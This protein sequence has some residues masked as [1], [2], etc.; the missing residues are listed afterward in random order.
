MTPSPTI[1]PLIGQNVGG[2]V[3]EGLI[4]E[5]GMGLVYRARHPILERRFAVKVLRPD[6][7]ADPAIAQN[8]IREAQTLSAI[9]HPNIIDI[10]GF[11][12]LD[13]GRQFMVTE[14]L[15]GR[16]VEHELIE[17]GRI[18]PIR[19]L[20]LVDQV[21]SALAAA[22]SVDVV[23]RDLKPSNIFLARS[24][25]GT[26]IVKL[27]DFGLAKQQPAQLAAGAEVAGRSVV[28]GTPEYVAPEQASGEVAGT[29]SDLYSLGVT[30]FEMLTGQRPFNAPES[31]ER[32]TSLMRMHM[33]M[34]APLIGQDFPLELEQLVA[35]LLSKQPSQRPASAEAV[36]TRLQPIRR[37]LE[38]EQPDY[39]PASATPAGGL[40]REPT[41]PRLLAMSLPA[42]PAPRSRGPLAA[43]A[44]GGLVVLAL[45]AL[46]HKSDG[47]RDEDE[48]EPK[49][50]P[51]KV[52]PGAAEPGKVALPVAP[53]D[54]LEALPVLPPPPKPRPATPAHPRPPPVVQ[55]PTVSV[56]AE[57][58]EPDE[59]WRSAARLH[60]EEVQQL[61]AARDDSAA[62]AEFEKR[63]DE[64]SAAIAS[65][66]TARQCAEVDARIRA[67]ATG[68]SK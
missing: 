17:R 47:G 39:H 25:D 63:E 44:A 42:P 3:I 37:Q 66:A 31:P 8:F 61:I 54:E 40:R 43:A 6:V 60:L 20:L 12:P 5:G 55:A 15:D 38:A 14:F 4:G 34:P 11:G 30:L 24:S 62:W 13:D 7:A 18:A 65:A 51:V 23:H 9:K 29:W 28:A 33:S 59:R 27:L 48:A 36:R 16:T 35:E 19:A 26:E 56:T 64:V 46:A 50:A 49:A 32:V 57:T 67:L 68:A 52:Q 58:C 2:F 53:P 45:V 22:H 1:D 10:V 41:P 21:L